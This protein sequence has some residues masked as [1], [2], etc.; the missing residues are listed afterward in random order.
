MQLCYQVLLVVVSLGPEKIS[1]ATIVSSDSLCEIYQQN[2]IFKEKL[3]KY[4][5]N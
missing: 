2:E 1:F 4:Y 3:Q 5:W